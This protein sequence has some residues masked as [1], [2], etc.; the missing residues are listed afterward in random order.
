MYN[1]NGR[2]ERTNTSVRIC[3][4]KRGKILENKDISKEIVKNNTV[5]KNSIL[6]EIVRQ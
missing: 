5:Y 3:N 1:C 2:M 6:P 4:I